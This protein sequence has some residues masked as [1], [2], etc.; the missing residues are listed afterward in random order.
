MFKFFTSDL[1][2]NLIKI[3][4]LTVGLAVGFLLIAKIYFEQTYDSFMPEIDRLYI[5]SESVVENG[6]YKEYFFT[7][8]GTAPELQSVIPEI[9]VATRITVMT[10]GA[11][12][13]LEDGRKFDM[14]CVTI[15][16]SCLFDVLGTPIMEGNPHDVLAVENQVMIPQSLAEKIGDDVIGKRISVVEWGDDYKATIGGVYADYPLNST[17]KNAVYLSMPTI[18]LFMWEGSA[19]NLIGNDR[20]NSYVLLSKDADPASIN[21]KMVEHLKTKI[22]EEAFT[23]GDY[24]VWLRPLYGNYTSDKGVRTMTWLLGILAFMILVCA[25]LNYLLIV[26][27]QFSS[28]GKEMA[29]RKCYGTGRRKI[30]MLVLS[31][32]LFFLIIS[33]CLALLLSFSFADLCVDLLGYT[34]KVLFSIKKVWVVEGLVCLLLFLIT[35]ILPA[36]IYCYTPVGQAFKS[37]SHGKKV[38]KLILLA[39][40]FFSTGLVMCMLVL[41]WRQYHMLERMPWGL[42][43]EYI[44]FFYHYPLS[45]EKTASIIEEIEKLPFVK[46]V[47][48]ADRNPAD[49]ASG[50][51][52]WTEGQE[53]NQINIADCEFVN[54]KLF[55]IMDIQFR[56]GRNFS[57]NSDSTINEVIVDERM[58]E[59][60]QKYFGE[61]DSDIIGKQLIVTGHPFDDVDLHYFTIVGV[62]GDIRR[63]GFDYGRIDTRAGIYFPASNARGNVYVRFTE[64]TPDNLSAVQKVIDSIN[65]MEE[66]Y[67]TPYKTLIESKLEGILKFGTSVM[68]VGLVIIL[69][70]LVGLIGY[71]GD[72]VNRRA[73]EIAIRKVNGTDAR[74]IVRLFCIDV[75]KVALPSLI[76][77]GTAA[78]IIGQR[79]LSQFTDRVSLSPISMIACLL[80][81]LLLIMAVVIINTLRVARSN[82]VDHL[83]SE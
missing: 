49:P 40:Q 38:W 32:S 16:D 7:P 23:I 28:R 75:M 14:P 74:K 34:P 33:V 72:E 77:G 30:F 12:I 24:K 4:C 11:V 45:D 29:I 5:I 1:R 54:P 39:V 78:M 80:I 83:R 69:I 13:K 71:V 64:F 48:T 46:G 41:V 44:G 17:M 63:G 76:L 55:D 31:E 10:W 18:K 3:L 36:I 47:A 20:Y 56:Q 50:N 57:E 79:W 21:P 65:D 66:I 53:E 9:E 15:A 37:A 68:I 51:M 58:I 73:K 82:P 19:T 60:L 59:V 61:T 70:A 42:D 62:I 52:M 27:G 8:G 81:L 26:I 2:R 43:Y 22:P 35:G 6:E 25:G 67:I